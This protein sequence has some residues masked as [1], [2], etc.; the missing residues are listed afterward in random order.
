MASYMHRTFA[1]PRRARHKSNAS[2]ELLF[3]V[4]IVAAAAGTAFWIS[5]MIG[6][7]LSAINTAASVL[8]LTEADHH[9]AVGYVAVA[10]AEGAPGAPY[11]SVGQK[12]ALSSGASAL[13]TQIGDVMGTPLECEHAV[14]G[15]GDTVQMTTT[16]LIAYDSLRNTVSFTDGWRHWAATPRGVVA[17]EGT[18]STPPAG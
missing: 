17:W 8:G 10:A 13:R 5:H 7:D 2:A 3:L 6:I 12:P 9:A 15:N 4:I 11:C 18:E 1:V 14:S 16:G